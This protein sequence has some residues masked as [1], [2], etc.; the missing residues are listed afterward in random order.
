MNASQYQQR[1]ARTANPDLP[2]HE[3]CN[4]AVLGLIGELGEIA[5]T[6]KKVNHQGHSIEKLEKRYPTGFN[7]EASI[8]RAA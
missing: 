8:N 6:L 4:N 7:G 5:D 1:A 2:L 3:R